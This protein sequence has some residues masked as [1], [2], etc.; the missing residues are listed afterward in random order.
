MIFNLYFLCG[1]LS[2][3]EPVD[4]FCCTCRG[5]LPPAARNKGKKDCVYSMFVIHR[6]PDRNAWRHRGIFPCNPDTF[7][8]KYRNGS[9]LLWKASVAGVLRKLGSHLSDDH[10]FNAPPRCPSLY[11]L[12]SMAPPVGKSG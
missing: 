10:C 2:A 6:K 5:E 1:C 11:L 8:V 4:G 7:S 9:V 12:T 3:A